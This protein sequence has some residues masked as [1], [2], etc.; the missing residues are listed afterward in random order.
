MLYL[1]CANRFSALL[2]PLRRVL[3]EAAPDPFV[4]ERIAVSDLSLATWLTQRL[5]EE[6]GVVAQL[7]FERPLAALESLARAGLGLPPAAVPS[8]FG[9]EALTWRIYARWP[10]L[11]AQP[12]FAA[13]RAYLATEPRTLKRYRLS[14]RLA[15]IFVRCMHYRPEWLRAWAAG[16]TPH[17]PARL[18]H[19]LLNEEAPDELH[20]AQVLQRLRAATTLRR[21]RL[22]RR[23]LWF[24]V[25]EIPPPWGAALALLARR[26]DLHLFALVPRPFSVP[27]AP[28]APPTS[29]WLAL[30]DTRR[31]ALAALAAS[32]VT[33]A[34][35]F[36]DPGDATRLARLQRRLLGDTAATAP[37]TAP[38]ARPDDA[39]DSVQLHV[40]H[41]PLREVQVLYDRLLALFARWPELEPR[42][43]LVMMPEPERYAPFVAATFG[44][45]PPARRI[46]W[47]IAERPALDHPLLVALFE[48]LELPQRRLGAAEVFAWLEVPAIGRRFGL[49]AD[50][51]ARIRGWI[52]RSGIRWGL[53]GAMRAACDLPAEETHTWAFGLCRLFLGY[54]LPP[55]EQLYGEA[56]P[57]PDLAGQEAA[58]LG[59]LQQFIV[60]LTDW[61]AELAT[62]G[63]AES[64]RARLG[65]LIDACC[66]PDEDEEALLARLRAALDRLVEESTIGAADVLL[67]LDVVRDALRH[68]LAQPTESP[69]FGTGAVTFCALAP[70][71]A[72]PTRVL[73][74]LGMNAD[75][76]GRTERAPSFD[77]LAADPRPGDPD[78]QAARRA[79]FLDLVLAAGAVLHL[80]YCGRDP[81]DNRP[82]ALAGVVEELLADIDRHE[83]Q[84][85]PRAD[86]A[87]HIVIEHPLQPF[88]ARYFDGSAPQLYSHV[89]EWA[90]LSG[91]TGMAPTPF[92]G[93]ALDDTPPTVLALDE[94]IA[95]GCAPA[96]YFLE[97]RLGIPLDDPDTA[98]Y[99]TLPEREPFVLS[100]LEQWSVR[101]ELEKLARTLPEVTP[102][103]LMTAGLRRLRAAGA[104][105]H[106]AAAEVVLA[107]QVARVCAQLEALGP[108]ERGAPLEF[109]QHCAGTRLHGWLAGPTARG[110][111]DWRLGVLRAKDLL[112]WWLR[113]LAYNALA[114]RASH[115]LSDEDGG[116]CWR[117]LAP[118]TDA[119]ERL[120]AWVELWRQGRRRPLPLFPESSYAWAVAS[121]DPRAAEAKVSQVWNS[122][123]WRAGESDD[124][125]LRLAF[126]DYPE[127]LGAEFQALA[128]DVFT[129]LLAALT[130]A[131]PECEP[132]TRAPSLRPRRRRT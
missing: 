58:A 122:T 85:D 64:W 93:A 73:C 21:E 120:A 115:Y 117:R 59:A 65:A 47:V 84:T 130:D 2:P 75:A 5:A 7:R 103:G 83:P 108:V 111:L 18:W 33:M 26:M 125:A 104:L 110:P 37:V 17:W 6:W 106:G 55:D 86:A 30:G 34:D 90:A 40:C 13:P 67:E 1:H 131:A 77:P 12:A 41:S 128:M 112:S 99:D 38:R 109:E 22:P 81:R 27:N 29:P 42:E 124:A 87:R 95:F 3:A 44:A 107:P 24:G 36:V 50:E 119:P 43:V 71:R 8:A 10:A 63:P 89:D 61:R 52:A 121:A 74:L 126:R 60:A 56:F 113:H 25:T 129:P 96:R 97:R 69:R 4:G 49:G 48:L 51:L 118:V 9:L 53:D 82:R 15:A 88:A 68:A 92:V 132:K 91:A 39:D 114:P 127:P 98:R 72:P 76:W 11:L 79:L 31:A 54:A 102:E 20:P 46:P 16:D 123:P 70:G 78:P 19:A 100:K 94:L 35:D 80:S 101:Q 116:P 62:A 28:S 23:W 105:P 32:G 45:A 14:Q 57:D 66:A